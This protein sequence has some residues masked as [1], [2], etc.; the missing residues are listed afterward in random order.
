MYEEPWFMSWKAQFE[1]LQLSKRE[2]KSIFRIFHAVSGGGEVA[3]N[4]GLAELFTHISVERTVFTERVFS[5]FDEDGSDEIDFREFT[6]ALWNFCTLSGHTLE[7]FVFNLYDDDRSGALSAKEVANMLKDIYGSSAETNSSSKALLEDLKDQQHRGI[8][9]DL[10]KFRRYT[11]SHQAMLFPVFQLQIALRENILGTGFWLKNMKKR[12]EMT[13]DKFCPVGEFLEGEMLERGWCIVEET[14]FNGK[15]QK[16]FVRSEALVKFNPNNKTS[17]TTSTSSSVVPGRATTNIEDGKAALPERKK[18]V[19]AEQQ[20]YEDWLD[21][22]ERN[23]PRPTSQKKY[24]RRG[25]LGAEVGVG[26]ASSEAIDDSRKSPRTDGTKS[27]QRSPRRSS[28]VP[29]SNKT[30]EIV[31][32]SKKSPRK[33]SSADIEPLALYESKRSPRPGSSS[34]PQRSPRRGCDGEDNGADKSPRRP[35]MIAGTYVVEAAVKAKESNKNSPRRGS[36]DKGATLSPRESKKS[37]RKDA[38]G[39]CDLDSLL[40]KESK[41]SPRRHG[42]I[43]GDESG[44]VDGSLRESKKSPRRC[45]TDYDLLAQVRDSK[46]SGQHSPRRG[47]VGGTASPQRSPRRGSADGT[48]SPQRSPRRGSVGAMP[49]VATI[50]EGKGMCRYSTP[51]A[52]YSCLLRTH[53]FPSYSGPS[54][55]SLYSLSL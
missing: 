53:T 33:L 10:G 30:G 55:P 27:P 21:T 50:Q 51:H 31:Q 45:S 47:S 48:A 35:S 14:Q 25:S 6:I 54:L 52:H 40:H 3:Q 18:I 2:L 20:L 38:G 49:S 9:F 4:V 32:D 46:K 22:K 28:M 12:K 24:P 36:V 7:T 42:S 37:P 39:G 41:T 15:K 23:D 34:S 29:V 11:H 19:T 13:F 26:G 44:P 43:A 16:I 8:G 17:T 1:C 5:I